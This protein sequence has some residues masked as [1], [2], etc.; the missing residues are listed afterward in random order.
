MPFYQRAASLGGKSLGAGLGSHPNYRRS[1]ETHPLLHALLPANLMICW[2]WLTPSSS[3]AKMWP[4]WLIQDSMCVA[5]ATALLTIYKMVPDLFLQLMGF[6]MLLTLAK[7]LGILNYL[8]R[9]WGEG[10]NKQLVAAL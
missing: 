2:L 7:P 1:M 6:S 10:R 9:C 4:P 8:D 3:P 5:S